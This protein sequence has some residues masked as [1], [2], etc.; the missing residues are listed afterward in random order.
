MNPPSSEQKVTIIRRTIQ[1]PES[2]L[3]NRIT[4]KDQERFSHAVATTRIVVPDKQEFK[5]S[6]RQ[7][8]ASLNRETR[9]LESNHI[10]FS[11]IEALDDDKKEERP[12]ISNVSYQSIDNKYG[13]VVRKVDRQTN[14]A[15]QSTVV[16]PKKHSEDIDP[17]TLRSEIARPKAKD[18]AFP[19]PFFDKDDQS[20]ERSQFNREVKS[21]RLIFKRAN[22]EEPKL[23]IQ[24]SA[25]PVELDTKK[26]ELHIPKSLLKSSYHDDDVVSQSYKSIRLSEPIATVLGS[27]KGDIVS[28]KL[29][30]QGQI[31]DF[32]DF[33]IYDGGFKDNAFDGYGILFNPIAIELRE[34]GLGEFQIVENENLFRDLDYVGSNWQKYE[35]IFKHDK[36]HKIGFWH[37]NN[38]DVF[39][40]EFYDDKANGYGTYNTVSGSSVVGIWKD[41][42]LVETL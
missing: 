42:K 35:G 27:Y 16:S 39:F 37:L 40:G 10:G 25:H 30:G 34:E 14:F 22:V 6:L 13:L 33:V 21:E 38:G 12:S 1:Q 18:Q 41:N 7:N 26:Q 9:M 3:T 29:C 11:N 15:F 17:M 24:Y 28:G 19:S 5:Y 4:R 31:L 32:N 2:L 20:T 8:F 36:K 23:E